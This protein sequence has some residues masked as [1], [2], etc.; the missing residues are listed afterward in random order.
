MRQSEGDPKVKSALR[1][2]ARRILQ[3][4]M[5]KSIQTA[6]VVVTNPVH[7][8]VALRYDR[9][10]ESAPTIVA[11][12]EQAFARRLKAAAAQHGVPVVENPPV[13]RM[14]YKFGRVGK[15]IPVNLYHAVA[16]ILAFVYK[17]HRDYF[18]DLQRRRDES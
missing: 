11:K 9:K 2:M 5:L 14:L 8:A 10:Q 13:A 15:P 1:A 16:E 6:D 4:Q 18:R 7:F 12:G 17:S 3:R